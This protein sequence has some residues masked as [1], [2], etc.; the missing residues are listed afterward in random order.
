VN[1]GMG[2]WMQQMVTDMAPASRYAVLGL[3]VLRLMMLI[4]SE[5]TT[6]A[7]ATTNVIQLHKHQQYLA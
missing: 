2:R 6:P 3:L 1:A 4:F 5:A 7:A